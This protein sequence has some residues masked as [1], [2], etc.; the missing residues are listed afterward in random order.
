MGGWV[1]CGGGHSRA[2]HVAHHLAPTACAGGHHRLGVDGLLPAA[3]VD[4]RL[5]AQLCVLKTAALCTEGCSAMHPGRA[6]THSI[7]GALGGSALLCYLVITPAGALR[8]LKVAQAGRRALPLAR[9]DLHGP[10][11]DQRAQQPHRRVQGGGRQ[12]PSSLGV[13]GLRSPWLCAHCGRWR[14]GPPS[15]STWA[16]LTASMSRASPPSTG[17][18]RMRTTCAPHLHCMRTVCTCHAHAHAHV[19]AHVTCHAHACRREQFEYIMQT[20]QW[21]QVQ[22]AEII[23]GTFEVIDFSLE[24]VDIE[25]LRC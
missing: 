23:G 18:H 22:G 24:T 19:H 3:R 25:E 5:G 9:A 2:R 7:A 13:A 17:A 6:P 10:A 12:P 8:A 20:S 16:P 21:C 11:A 14:S 4:V 1:G 15:A